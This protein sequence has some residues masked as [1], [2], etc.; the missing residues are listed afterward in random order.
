MQQSFDFSM[1]KHDNKNLFK[2]SYP[3]NPQISIDEKNKNW[4]M[5]HQKSLAS[6][7]FR[8]YIYILRRK[9]ITDQN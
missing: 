5:D 6:Q 4:K 3:G 2:K 7:G 9:N 1:H 8:I